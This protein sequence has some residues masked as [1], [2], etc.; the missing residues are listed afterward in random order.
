VVHV[1]ATRV[2]IGRRWASRDVIADVIVV[3]VVAFDAV[4]RLA[5]RRSI[6]P[7]TSPLIGIWQTETENKIVCFITGTI[8]RCTLTQLP[9]LRY[10]SIQASRGRKKI[11]K[12]CS[13][14]AN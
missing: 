12:G 1:T 7:A 4:S 2:A 14:H 13:Q 8:V 10:I 6:L 11:L 5:G 9:P 3:Q